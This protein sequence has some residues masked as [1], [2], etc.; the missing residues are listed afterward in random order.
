MPDSLSQFYKTEIV[1]TGRLPMLVLLAGIIV[2]FLLLR[3]NTRLIRK[4][5]RWWPGNLE[6][7]DMHLHHVAIGLPIMFIS[8]VLEFAFRPGFPWAEIVALCF[9]GATAVVFDEYALL[10]HVRDVYWEKEGRHSVVAVFLAA[11]F[12][13]FLVV[14]VVPLAAND[15]TY[16]EAVSRWSIA[17]V[18]AVNFTFVLVSFLKGK[19]WMGWIGFFLPVVAWVG[20]V[21][22]GRPNS[23]W[24]RWFYRRRPRQLLR[25]ERREV[26]FASG[27]GHWRLR[28][29][30]LV[31]GAPDKPHMHSAPIGVPKAAPPAAPRG[32]G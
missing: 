7:G 16:S 1:H 18:A 32:G 20:A 21:R 4:G 5:V 8:G 19:I 3:L 17:L 2:T 15:S 6:K 31:S 10:L 22:L 26:A 30:D 29:S 13:A 9:G 24:A 27:I 28:F 12:T 14:G 23:P 11:T 25:A